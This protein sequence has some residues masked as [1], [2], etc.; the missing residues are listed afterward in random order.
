MIFH[1][2]PPIVQIFKPIIA[3]FVVFILRGCFLHNGL[4]GNYDG[5]ANM[6]SMLTVYY[7]TGR[8]IQSL[9]RNSTSK[10]KIFE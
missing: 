5:D 9:S 2:I 10:K 3:L 6:A 8:A 7:F 4:N 1:I